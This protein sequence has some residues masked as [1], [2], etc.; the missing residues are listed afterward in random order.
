MKRGMMAALAALV[1]TGC[2]VTR[3]VPPAQTYHLQAEAVGSAEHADAC[4]DR[5][6]RV[7]LLQSPKWLRGTDIYYG[8]THRK[9]YRYTRARW[10]M[11]PSDQLQQIVENAVGDRVGFAAVVPYKSLAKNDWLLE[12]RLEKMTQVIDDDGS[13]RT[14][15]KLYAVVLEQYSRHIVAERT[16]DYRAVQEKGDVDSATAAWS[17]AVSRFETDLTH[18]LAGLC[19]SHPLPDKRDVDL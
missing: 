18:W 10:E 11:P 9:M 3:E 15:L 17:A 12:V 19:G 4:G 1:F 2:S 5:V 8:D 13:A 16:F 6:L 14:E 7:A